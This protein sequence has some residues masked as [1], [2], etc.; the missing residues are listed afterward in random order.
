MT[1]QS[2]ESKIMTKWDGLVKNE[3]G[4]TAKSPSPAH[5]ESHLDIFVFLNAVPVTGGIYSVFQG[6]RTTSKIN[7]F[8]SRFLDSDA[9]SA[10]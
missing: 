2:I 7:I 3:L 4:L 10:A 1:S 9:D 5:F 6:P 8:A